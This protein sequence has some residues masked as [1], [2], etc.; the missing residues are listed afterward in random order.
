MTATP[1][2][3][4]ASKRGTHVRRVVIDISTPAGWIVRHFF[5]IGRRRA[6]SIVM[7]FNP[8]VFALGLEVMTGV[9]KGAAI[10]MGPL[11][12]GFAVADTTQDQD[13]G[14]SE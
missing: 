8:H 3:P 13:G 4:G 9:G 6:A 2:L 14:S 12:I 11:W 1:Q 7:A 10:I 5:R